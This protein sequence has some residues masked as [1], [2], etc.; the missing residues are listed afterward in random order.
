MAPQHGLTAYLMGAQAMRPPVQPPPIIST[1]YVFRRCPAFEPRRPPFNR[2]YWPPTVRKD[3]IR[4]FPR[5][6]ISL[7]ILGHALS[8]VGSDRDFIRVGAVILGRESN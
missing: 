4:C 6:I 8:D 2:R 3:A 7:G 5:D 1:W